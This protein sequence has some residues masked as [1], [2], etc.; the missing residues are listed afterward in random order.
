MSRPV[1]P[2]LPLLPRPPAPRAGCSPARVQ[3]S[4]AGRTEH[5]EVGGRR[6]RQSEAGERAGRSSRGGQQQ[7]GGRSWGLGGGGLGS[8]GPRWPLHHQCLLATMRHCG[9]TRD[10]QQPQTQ[11]PS[12]IACPYRLPLAQAAHLLGAGRLQAV[13]GE[14]EVV[15]PQLPQHGHQYRARI[16]PAQ[17][18]SKNMPDRGAVGAAQ[19]N[20]HN[21]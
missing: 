11:N 5:S 20:R 16:V 14:G 8:P 13:A 21:T 18:W 4:P 3:C 15:C 12:A 1:T 7:E 10:T 2:A 6:S 19:G 9:E 17:R